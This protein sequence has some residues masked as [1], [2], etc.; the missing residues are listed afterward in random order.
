MNI[1][2]TVPT[3][4]KPLCVHGSNIRSVIAP[5]S[6]LEHENVRELK[7]GLG[8]L[9]ERLLQHGK[10]ITAFYYNYNITHYIIF[11]KIIIIPN[12]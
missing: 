6:S 5:H 10:G 7:T 3:Q 9:V 12:E 11:M 1:S 4:P 8:P 2:S